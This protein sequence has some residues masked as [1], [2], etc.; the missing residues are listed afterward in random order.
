MMEKPH[1]NLT[2]KI[3]K[4]AGK[5]ATLGAFA[6]TLTGVGCDS[7]GVKSADAK[8]SDDAKFLQGAREVVQQIKEDHEKSD[9]VLLKSYRQHVKEGKLPLQG[10]LKITPEA[11]ARGRELARDSYHAH[12]HTIGSKK[13]EVLE[14]RGYV[15]TKI[16]VG[17][18]E[19]KYY[20]HY[21]EER[22]MIK[23]VEQ[24]LGIKKQEV[25]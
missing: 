16:K 18:E 22:E 17:G 1:F 25:K 10:M 5:T 8:K 21:W 9:P 13:I 3:K 19:L 14:V 6:A 2:E 15:P 20:P 23:G 7:G 12:H 24:A 11:M 4:V